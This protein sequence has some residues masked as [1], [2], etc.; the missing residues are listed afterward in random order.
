MN[1]NR[2]RIVFNAKRGLRMAVAETAT[3]QGKDG[4]G[5]TRGGLTGSLIATLRTTSFAVSAALGLVPWIQAPALAQIVADPSAPANQRATVLQTANG[6]PQVNIQT[7]S[8]AGVSRNTYNQFDVQSNGAILNNSRTNVQTQTGGWVQGNPW[9]ATGSARVILNEVNSV[10]PSQL[11]GYV[12]VANQR[13]EV[14]IANPAGINVD[15]GGFINASR[16]MLTTGTPVMNGGSLDGYRVQ[17]GSVSING[18]GLDTGTADYTGILARAVQVNAGIWAKELHVVT[19]ANQIDAAQTSVSPITGTSGRSPAFA[20][21]VAQLGAMYA[22][23][24]FLI[25][26]EAGVGV[27]NSGVIGATA[28]DV[29]LQSNG[30]LSNSGSIQ[31]SG[32]TTVQAQTSVS[33]TGLM[34]AQ[35]SASISGTQVNVVSGKIG[36]QNINLN[37]SA[38]D[39][40]ATR[41]T[42]NAQ[43]TLSANAAQ[44]LRTD[45]AAVSASQ[46]KLTAREL[47]NVGGEILQTGAGDTAIELAGNL[48]NTQGRIA[49]N[50]ANLALRADT[51]TNTDG[52]IEHAG[53]G[54]LSIN[55]TTLNDLRGKIT[56][57]GALNINTSAFNHD[58]ASTVA[59]QISVAAASISNRAGEIIQTGAGSTHITA[60]GALDNSAGTIASNGDTTLTAGSL[61]NSQGTITATQSLNLRTGDLNNAAGFIGAKGALTGSAA[62]VSNTQGAQ[63]IRQSDVTF[64]ATGFDN[65]SGQVQALGNVSLDVGAGTI[66][67]TASLICSAQTVTL[68]AATVTNSNTQGTG[69]GIEGSNIAITVAAIANDS[70][71]MR[72]DNN[73]TLTSSGTLKNQAGLIS[74]GNALTVQ[75]LAASRALAVSNSGKLQAGNT[76]TVS[77]NN[78]DNAVTGEITGAT[79]KLSAADT[80]TNR[81][82]I[83]GQDAQVNA[84]TLNNL[85]TGRIYGDYL[86]IAAGTVTNDAETINGITTTATIAARQRLDIGAGTLTN[87]EHA[88]ILAWATWPLAGVWTPTGR[89]RARPAPLTTTAPPLRH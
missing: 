31:A 72:A 17:A 68:M 5:E 74:A 78:I 49:V 77:A 82:L 54:A 70:G 48:N 19:G 60:N 16:V 15:G 2:Y 58:N 37:A 47:S 11:K 75:D 59:R 80:L 56:G 1:T 25:G 88:L 4:G 3:A 61:N 69:Q 71:A 18:L 86:S 24:I 39:V 21:D 43:G 32:N 65:R 20:L 89:L 26:T 36:A 27:R 66:D 30:W 52:K 53:G 50:S 62:N 73:I 10:N 35:G 41:A 7:P 23:K 67:N 22:D 12:E 46:L 55:T 79:T 51:L 57:N 34:T 28:G 81:G 76:L 13:A 63:I 87:R 6:L 42:L 33:N 8:A 38:G 29:V 44:T 84:A 83:D 45:G 85:S 14:I 64:T 40:D 9:L